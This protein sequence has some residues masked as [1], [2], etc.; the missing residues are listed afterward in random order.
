MYYYENQKKEKGKKYRTNIKQNNHNY[1]ISLYVVEE[2][3]QI[4]INYSNSYSDEIFEYTNFYSFHQLQIIN[5]YFRYFDNIEKICKDLDKLLKKNKV[6][7]DDKNVYLILSIQVLIKKEK[8][9]IIFKLKKKAMDHSR[10]NNDRLNK[11][12]KQNTNYYN[13]DR[14]KNS[15]SMPKYNE[16]EESRLK[17]LLN[18]LNERVSMLEYNNRY[19][20]APKEKMDYRNNRSNN[21]NLNDSSLLMG[22]INNIMI[23]MNK[24]ENLNKEKDDRLKELEDRI[25]K[26]EN[27]LSNTMSYPTYSLP[28]KSQKSKNDKDSNIKKKKNSNSN[29][30]EYE[31]E[32]NLG[33][34]NNINKSKDKSSHKLRG[35]KNIEKPKSPEYRFK[36]IEDSKEQLEDNNIELSKNKNYI[37]NSKDENSKRSKKN[38]IKSKSQGKI[39]KSLNSSEDDENK[40]NHRKKHSSY[41]SQKES[42]KSSLKDKKEKNN[43]KKRKEEERKSEDGEDTDK[44]I[45][46]EKESEKSSQKEEKNNKKRHKSNNSDSSEEKKHKKNKLNR[47]HEDIEKAMVKTGLHMVERE[48]LKNYIN[49]RIFFTTK[50]LQLVKYRITKNKEHLHCY[51]D[52]LYRASIDGD[53]ED[54]INNCCEGLYPQII[55]FY[56]SEG[57]RF[58][59]YIEKEKHVGFFGGESYKEV[60]GTSFL[61]SLNSLKTYDIKEGKKATDDRP[62]KVS[63]GRS[64]LLNNNGSNWFIFTPRNS[65]LGVKCMIGDKESTFGIINTNEIVGNNKEYTLKEVEIFNVVYF[66]DDEEDDEDENAKFI[67]EK[68]V[69]INNFSKKKRNNNNTIKIKNMK[70]E[71]EDN[72]ED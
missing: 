19:E 32:M 72:E 24:L 41:S 46:S 26:Y 42:E 4:S 17:N 38:N 63:F 6:S 1:S 53:Y 21:M 68:E 62:E 37:D 23:R 8:T 65:F 59:V 39:K 18:D 45:K 34:N 22:N 71:N 55:L 44:N 15:I 27:N 47:S 13:K 31:Y 16:E 10:N 51:F 61:F 29:E 58:G 49:S 5:K 9:N 14:S 50:E 54:R 36:Q 70:I 64:F 43:I 52:I 35:K 40:K 11:N 7:I 66:S 56:A 33:N 3:L 25:S 60:P 28:N 67:K 69:R 48:D 12:Y 2:K 20:S 57:P 30:G